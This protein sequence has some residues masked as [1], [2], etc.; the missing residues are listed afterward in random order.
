MKFKNKKILIDIIIMISL[1]LLNVYYFLV[2]DALFV[3]T[4]PFLLL[5]A[6]MLINDCGRKL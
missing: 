5:F 6:Y 3:A 2:G 4:L 1:F